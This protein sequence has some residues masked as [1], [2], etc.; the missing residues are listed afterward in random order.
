MEEN[1]VLNEK[2]IKQHNKVINCIRKR[3]PSI[4]EEQIYNISHFS[5][6]AIK[7]FDS[8]ILYC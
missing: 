2:Q 1:I 5:T 7:L 6:K 8:F 3:I 4:S